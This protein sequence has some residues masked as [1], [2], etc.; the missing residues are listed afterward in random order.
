M[1]KDCLMRLLAWL[2]AALLMASPALAE[3]DDA[4]APA[5]MTAA[6]DADVAEADPMDLPDDDA[7]PLDDAIEGAWEAV[8]MEAAV[9]EVSEES[10]AE[11][12]TAETATA[13]TAA[14]ETAIAETAAAETAAEG[15]EAPEQSA[16]SMPAAEAVKPPEATAAQKPDEKAEEKT[17]E[18]AEEKPA[19]TSGE[20]AE[21][22]TEEP[23]GEKAEEQSEESEGEKPEEKSEEPEGE[24]AE[25]KSEEP[26]G[27][28]TEESDGEKTEEK[29]EKPD[30]EGTEES[31]EEKAEKSGEEKTE[32][33]YGDEAGVKAAEAGTAQ[34]AGEAVSEKAEA[35]AP[36]PAAEAPA[37]PVAEEA[38]APALLEAEIYMG[39]GEKRVLT[40][41]CD[42]SAVGAIT[43]A[44]SKPGVVSVSRAGKLTARKRGSA[45]ITVATQSGL[46][47]SCLVHVS[48]APA[49]VRILPGKKLSMGAGESFAFG[50]K[51][52]KGASSALRWSSSN[53]AVVSI[54]ALGVA[55]ASAPG[56]AKIVVKTFN[57]RKA[58]CKVRV[59]AAPVAVAL[60]AGDQT[61]GVGMTVN[62]KPIVNAGAAA[63]IVL[64]S[65]NPGVAAVN[66]GKV[67]GVSPGTAVITATTYNGLAAAATVTV[68]PAPTAVGLGYATLH[69]GVGEKLTLRPAT[70]P[71]SYASF[72]YKSSKKSVVRVSAG[73][74]IKA[75]KRGTATVTVTTYNGLRTRVKVKVYKAPSKLTLKPKS[76]AM[77]PGG[78]YQ[79][80]A[81]VPKG[82]A[83]MVTFASSDPG[84][85]SVEPTG[86]LRAY[87]IGTAT[88]TAVT[89]N[90]KKATCKV[91]VGDFS[92]SGGT[93][94][95]DGSVLTLSNRGMVMLAKGATWSLTA[96]ATGGL[97][98][99]DWSTS[100]KAIASISANGASCTIKGAG[101]GTAI[102]GAKL[103]SGA[104]ASVIVMVVDTGDLSASNFN[105]VQKALLAHED[106]INSDAGGNVIWDMVSAKLRKAGILQERVNSL[107]ATLR[108]ADPTYRNL[109]LYSLGTYDIVAE[110]ASLS[111][112]YFDQDSDKLYLK[113]SSNY[114][115]GTLYD[116]VVF[117]ESGHAI[118]WNY[119]GGGLD[120]LNDE[121][122][123]AV[124]GDVR[125]LLSD[126]VGAAISASGVTSAVD[127][128]KVVDALMDYRVLLKPDMLR[129]ELGLTEDEVTVYNRL[130]S[131]MSGEMNT[132]LPINNGCMVW[133]AV[134]GA[135]NY[136]VH[137]NFGHYYLFN[138]QYKEAAKTYYYNLQG[139]PSITT[140]PWAEFFSANLMGDTNTLQKNWSYLPQTCKYF[141][142]T[143][144]PKLV[145]YFTDKIKNA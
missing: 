132:T 10:A 17:S 8:P 64:S 122:T 131:D 103:P 15:A 86:V 4:L 68:V 74:V 63:N 75:R 95:A 87:R 126:R 141:A 22:K 50:A 27:E 100:S 114:S 24:K 33:K 53:P 121:A 23:E 79:L 119:N 129:N 42:P 71:G 135:T 89:Y 145:G 88:I 101:V 84:V 109:Y 125:S 137:G 54:N 115:S 36:E 81:V 61:V 78:T 133:D 93:A 14:D 65:D 56:T 20:K 11:T 134:E 111:A 127:G 29:S 123:A 46:S 139:T 90:R 25:E 34:E 143:F 30:G 112:S 39:K 142:E 72:T 102:V 76:L 85:V 19:A 138:T 5:I 9:P 140:E 48:R 35:A 136:A 116:Y 38:P 70:N 45:V 43:W 108:G 12:V 1:K 106:L 110:K 28:K 58:A 66:G 77:E 6:V 107:I 104:S 44:S 94:G 128:N 98:G 13:V 16:E 69:M 60:S 41:A 120:S 59:C 80:K 32:D 91:I 26:D 99:I 31:G 52:S 55:T 144:V 92:G 97:K 73:G 96:T 124:L 117:H 49:K 3:A 7:E 113:R 37:A 67:T 18:K 2:L 57:G 118:D 21:E 82:S 83:A 47:A 51:L 105:N 62:M 130:A 40:P